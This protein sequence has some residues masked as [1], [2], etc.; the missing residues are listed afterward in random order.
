MLHELYLID[1]QIRLDIESCIY[2]LQNKV[3][4]IRFPKKDTIY[5]YKEERVAIFKYNA[6]YLFPFVS[7]KYK[8][9]N[10]IMTGV[11]QVVEYKCNKYF[12]TLKCWCVNERHYYT[13]EKIIVDTSCKTQQSKNAFQ[14]LNALS[15]FGLKSEDGHELLTGQYK[16]IRNIESNSL[17]EHYLTANSQYNAHIIAITNTPIFP[18]GC[19]RSQ[20]SAVKNALC[21]QISIIQGPPGTGKT[22]TILNIIANLLVAEK[23][24]QVVSNNNSAVENIVEKLS[25][26]QYSMDFLVAYLGRAENQEYFIEHQSGKYP[27]IK[28]WK[29]EDEQLDQLQQQITYHSSIIQDFYNKQERLATIENELMQLITEQK[30]FKQFLISIAHKSYTKKIKYLSSKHILQKIQSIERDIEKYNRISIFRKAYLYFLQWLGLDKREVDII[31]TLKEQYYLIR[32]HEL[33]IEQKE[34]QQYIEANKH[35]SKEFEEA[36]LKY[37]K[38]TL[39]KRYGTLE[40]RAIFD[41]YDLKQ[42]STEFLR[43]YPIVLSTTF[44]SLNNTSTEDKFDYLIMD[45]ASQVDIVTGALALYSANNAVVVGDLKQLPNVVTEDMKRTT[46]SLF[47][48]YDLPNGFKFSDNSFL[49]SL[50]HLFPN[51]PSVLLR[52]HYRCH[53]MIIGFCNKKFYGGELIVM[54]KG[55]EDDKAIN[56]VRTVSGNHA[57]G[58]ENVRQIDAILQDI[59]PHITVPSSEM[60]IIAPYNVQVR[61]LQKVLSNNHSYEQP[62]VATVHK[63]QGKEKDVIVLSTVDNQIGDFVD[64][65]NLLNV[66]ISRAKK[67]FYLVV[68]GDDTSDGNIKDLIS[69]IEYYHGN[70]IESKV[71]S[72]FDL[73]YSSYTQERISFLQKNKRISEYDSENIFYVLLRNILDRYELKQISV[74]CHCPLQMILPNTQLLTDEETRY[75]YQ[76]GTHIDFLMYDKASLRPLYAMEVDGCSFHKEGEAQ[77]ARDLLKDCILYKYNIPMRRF[78]TNESNEENIILSDLS[79]FGIIHNK[80]YSVV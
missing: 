63:F 11:E 22:Q 70:V 46:D 44:S 65:P 6:T 25:K 53:P 31:N 14:Y 75:A 35:I 33:T 67:K 5:S 8:D 50:T 60:G 47:N 7:V 40:E 39:Y 48:S 30:H 13:D 80:D 1:N 52:E 37:L 28:T 73:L 58:K 16:K 26:P 43:E 29:I 12:S 10:T 23:S 55:T 72:V 15:K 56:V 78:R 36:S 19:N 54:T 57:R 3:Y 42:N 20:Y 69:Y 45:E 41:A 4:K 79:N 59:F 77:Y 27:E 64:D 21:N 32:K 17:L 61:A 62:L 9:T 51:I 66:A 24:I 2:D 76:S 38:G 74:A 71:R 18:F 68:S 49:K 34:L